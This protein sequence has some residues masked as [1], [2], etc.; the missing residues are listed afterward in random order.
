MTSSK[1]AI[2]LLLSIAVLAVAG[3]I[4]LWS[5][6]QPPPNDYN[7][8]DEAEQ[9]DR[10]GPGIKVGEASN[11]NDAKSSEKRRWYQTIRERPTDW[12]LVLFSG[13]LVACTVG[14]YRS[15][16]K[17]ADAARVSAAVANKSIQLTQQ[18]M[19]AYVSIGPGRFWELDPHHPT[20]MTYHIIN[21][22]KLPATGLR[23]GAVLKMAPFPLPEDYAFPDIELSGNG[24]LHPGD[25]SLT[26]EASV[27]E[28]LTQEEIVTLL[29]GESPGMRIYIFGEARYETLG[30]THFTQFCYSMQGWLN[31]VEAAEGGRWDEI[32]DL[33]PRTTLLWH[34]DPTYNNAD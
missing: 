26:G 3:A 8:S 14:L 20:A 11:R 18:E 4:F 12:L 5:S 22:G 23:H 19:R 30:E 34:H 25:N 29:K 2:G 31:V 7:Q 16:E 24:T 1:M 28:P 32:N 21:R 33:I 15:T 13:L 10:L 17:A 9:T 27:A 6:R